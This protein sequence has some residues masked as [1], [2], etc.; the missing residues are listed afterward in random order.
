MAKQIEP[1]KGGKINSHD[2]GG[3]SRSFVV[4]HQTPASLHKKAR[5][6]EIKK[7]VRDA[8]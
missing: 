5:K 8:S 2:L 1:S 3:Q 4:A 7:S 6:R